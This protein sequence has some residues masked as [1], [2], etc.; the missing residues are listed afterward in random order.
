MRV[1]RRDTN[2]LPHPPSHCRPFILATQTCGQ[3]NIDFS[4]NSEIIPVLEI[5]DF[6]PEPFSNNV[7]DGDVVVVERG[8]GG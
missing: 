2:D 5:E 8:G 6:C 3:H 7:G 4:M 1:D